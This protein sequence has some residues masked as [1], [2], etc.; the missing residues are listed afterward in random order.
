MYMYLESAIIHLFLYVQC[1]KYDNNILEMAQMNLTVFSSAV[2]RENNNCTLQLEAVT[3]DYIAAEQQS[4]TC[5][6][7]TEHK[8]N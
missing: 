8:H 5:E 1:I 7:W 3:V 2:F 6:R 4:K